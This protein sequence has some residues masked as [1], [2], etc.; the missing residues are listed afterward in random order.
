MIMSITTFRAIWYLDKNVTLINV[1]SSTSKYMDNVVHLY[2]LVSLNRAMLCF[3]E[4][5]GLFSTLCNHSEWGSADY[6]W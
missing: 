4:F 3:H 5:Q 6:T 1:T 2:L